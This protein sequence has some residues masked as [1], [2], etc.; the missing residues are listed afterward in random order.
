MTITDHSLFVKPRA[1]TRFTLGYNHHTGKYIWEDP[2]MEKELSLMIPPSLLTAF[3][4]IQEPLSPLRQL[5][6]GRVVVPV[7]KTGYPYWY[8]E[9]RDKIDQWSA[10]KK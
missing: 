10:T 2:E 7:G 4:G 5:I 1:P 6:E 3:N 9:V 8:L